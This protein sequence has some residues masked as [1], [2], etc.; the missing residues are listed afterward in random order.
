MIYKEIDTN[1][2]EKNEIPLVMLGLLFI[3]DHFQ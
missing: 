1:Q 2:I 3:L